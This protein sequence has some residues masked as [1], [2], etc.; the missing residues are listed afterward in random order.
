MSST[1]LRR[2]LRAAA[3]T[4]AACRANT[5]ALPTRATAIE[6]GASYHTA[7]AWR[8]RAACGATATTVGGKNAAYQSFGVASGAGVFRGAGESVAGKVPTGAAAL[9][10]ALQ[11]MVGSRNTRTLSKRVVTHALAR[12]PALLVARY[13]HS[14]HGSAKLKTRDPIYTS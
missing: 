14:D 1:V 5:A 8:S 6:I 4:V 10:F 9:P 2:G 12:S 11:M 7:A 13:S 3:S